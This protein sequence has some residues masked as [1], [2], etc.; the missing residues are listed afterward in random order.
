[1]ASF[2]EA[3][4]LLASLHSTGEE[5]K[6]DNDNDLMIDIPRR[7]GGSSTSVLDR[8][9]FLSNRA[10]D[11]DFPN[12][13]PFSILVEVIGAR[14]LHIGDMDSSFMETYCVVQYGTRTV[15]RTLPYRGNT[16]DQTGS[17]AKRFGQ[18]LKQMVVDRYYSD[19]DDGRQ[20]KA[21]TLLNPIWTIQHDALFSIDVTPRDMANHRALVMNLWARPLQGSNNTT[22]TS[23]RSIQQQLPTF[24]GKI[25]IPV[26]DLLG[27]CHEQRVEL[28]LV[29]DFDRAVVVD[30]DDKSLLAFRCRIA[31]PADLELTRFWNGPTTTTPR[32]TFVNTQR[33]VNDNLWTQAKV[34]EETTSQKAVLVTEL[35]ED[36]IQG[37]FLST[38]VAGAMTRPD[39]R[40]CVKPCPDPLW[41]RHQ[42]KKP[43]ASP[44]SS[45][46][47]SL[48][49]SS[50]SQMYLTP[51]ELKLETHKPSRQWVQGGSREGSLGRLYVEILSCHDLPN[52]DRGET[53]GNKTDAFCSLVYGDTMVQTDL[54]DDELSPHWMPWTQRAFVL[55]MS[56]GW[57][58]PYGQL[59]YIGVFGYKRKP[60]RRHRPIGRIEIHPLHFQRDTLYELEYNLYKDSH[61][62]HR[63]AQGTVRIRLRIE[64]DDERAAFLASFKSA[65][66]PL[67]PRIH[68]NVNTKKSWA[69]AQ[70]TARGEYNDEE[71]FQLGVLQGYI[72]E[73]I[74]GYLSR[75]IYALR[76]GSHSLIFW[77]AHNQL[78]LSIPGGVVVFPLYSLLTFVM[79]L[80]VVEHPQYILG[81]LCFAA[82]LFLFAQMEHRN[83]NPSPWKRCNSF[84][85]Y[86][87]I[88]LN[89]QPIR[90]E[91]I[92]AN[93]GWEETQAQESAFRARV[94]SEREF[95]QKKEAVEKEL[96]KLEHSAHIDTKS[97]DLIQ[98]ELLVVLG[99]VQGIIGNICRLLRFADT[100]ITWEESDLSFLL[101]VALFV[102]GS[103]I[104]FLPW[105][106]LLKWTGRIL[107]IVLFGPQNHLIHV[108][109]IQKRTNDEQKL[110]NL[111]RHRIHQVRCHLEEITRLKVFRQSVFGKYSIAVPSILWTPH[112][113]YPNPTSTAKYQ[114]TRMQDNLPGKE[115]IKGAAIG[116]FIVGKMIPRPLGAMKECRNYSMQQKETIESILA[117]PE[118]N[119]EGP[120]QTKSPACSPLNQIGRESSAFLDAGFE[121]AELFDEEAQYVKNVFKPTP[122]ESLRELGVEIREEATMSK[123]FL[124][125]FRSV[126]DFDEF[127]QDDENSSSSEEESICG[128]KESAN[129]V[130]SWKNASLSPRQHVVVARP[131]R[132]RRQSVVEPGVEVTEEESASIDKAV[133]KQS[134]NVE[135][136]KTLDLL[137][138]ATASIS[139]EVRRQSVVEL[140]VEVTEE[141]TEEAAFA[142]QSW[143]QFSPSDLVFPDLLA[144]AAEVE[145]TN[146]TLALSPCRREQGLKIEIPLSEKNDEEDPFRSSQSIPTSS[147]SARKL[148]RQQ[149][150]GDIKVDEQCEQLTLL[151]IVPI[152]TIWSDQINGNDDATSAG[153]GEAEDILMPLPAVDS[154]IQPSGTIVPPPQHRSRKSTF[155]EVPPPQPPKSSSVEQSS[156]QVPIGSAL[157]TSV[158]MDEG[159]SQGIDTVESD[160]RGFEIVAEWVSEDK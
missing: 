37:A 25:R 84:G 91:R 82:S 156:T 51:K 14:N 123:M 140:G 157:R 79:G 75:L 27:Q 76:D 39:G 20:E 94:E 107:V 38:A 152:P 86:V 130:T 103:T 155:L 60:I 113:D 43:P 8:L 159:E 160:D 21:T 147:S 47:A 100:I 31:S 74:Q 116:Q 5:K 118:A 121:V 16:A 32:T 148:P 56:E 99:K 83:R 153:E 85:H 115:K 58:N 77:Q 78:H 125:A 95:F 71:K 30:G 50:A 126:H 55:N 73:I 154:P 136:A 12:V 44:S 67:K 19:K 57:P 22:P 124:P 6:E 4:P 105:A 158:S 101:T 127:D 42:Q 132:A 35:P 133:D 117:M 97:T 2:T 128:D 145:H 65:L 141:F 46:R 49:P 52:V 137:Q 120:E 45:I 59:L 40:V 33:V 68:I 24:I 1:M 131:T 62:A 96:E 90:F 146:E 61:K 142:Q 63:R 9:S 26:Q 80:L 29:D 108:L 11:V 23:K 66:N 102:T 7:S 10:D 48:S 70:F 93:Q 151:S 64:M 72:D 109:Y 149:S 3:T 89:Q 54:I 119:I 88:L 135:T 138:P 28:P 15:H 92:E 41:A 106:F 110:R 144:S 53:L 87:R 129:A 104:L 81:I 139:K 114:G 69:V 122:Q 143:N 34:M 112:R 111:F 13:P 98:L 17:R 134:A 150:D 36:H 18:A